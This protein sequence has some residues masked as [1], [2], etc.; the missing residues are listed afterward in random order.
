MSGGGEE[1]AGGG[2]VDHRHQGVLGYRLELRRLRA[3]LHTQ[4][5]IQSFGYTKNID[6]TKRTLGPMDVF[7]SKPNHVKPEAPF[8]LL[9]LLF[10]LVASF[11]ILNKDFSR[12]F[13]FCFENL[14][15]FLV[16]Y[17]TPFQSVFL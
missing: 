4:Y 12:V 2:R 7:G 3:H 5:M 11:P 10:G 16:K 9:P 6:T 8:F 14:S 17:F 13:S 15:S 1:R